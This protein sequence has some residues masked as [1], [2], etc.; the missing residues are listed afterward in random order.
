MNEKMISEIWAEHFS[1][2]PQTIER[3]AVGH[4]NYVYIA[5]YKGDRYVCRCSAESGAYDNT[6]Y[7]LEKLS[8]I[9]I[10]VPKIIAKG[11]FGQYEYLIL[12][13]LEGKDIGLVY[14]QLKDDDKKVIA[15]E[16]VRI[17][18]RAAALKPED[19]EPDWSWQVLVEDML[20]RAEERILR[21]G[22]F[23][24]E[25]VERLRGQLGQLK[26]YFDSIKPVTYLDDI[27]SKN[28]LIHN[29]R[30]SGIID[31]DWI[32]TG[33]MLTFAAL[34]NMAL[35]N[36]EYDTDYVKYI[37]EEVQASDVERRAF[38]FYTLMYCVDFMGERGTVFMDK[39]V[40]VNA[41]IIDRL[42][43]IYDVLWAEWCNTVS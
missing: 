30:I 27:S 21:N 16:I 37:L 12:T 19:P 26:A 9:E 34:T 14:S 28:L 2:K 35:L 18:K 24:V 17:Q 20:D 13:Y 3:C 33:D 41:Q 1:G 11:R 8:A 22:Y 42:N 7:W 23:E 29:G 39:R 10:P 25:R 6:V 4:G 31:V 5:E 40:E 43:G 15:R 36:L 38:L 32:G